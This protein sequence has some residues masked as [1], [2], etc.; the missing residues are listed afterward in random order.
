MT[1][2]T[3]P[4]QKQRSILLPVALAT[5][6]DLSRVIHE[7]EK[8]DDFLRQSA[9]RQP[10]SP[11]QLPKTSKVFEELVNGSH[12]N[13]LLDDDRQYLEH[14]LEWMREKAPVMH[15]AFSTDPSPLF[16]ERLITWLRQ[17]ISPYVLIRIGLHPNIGAGCVVRSTNKYFDFSLR[18]RFASKRELLLEQLGVVRTAATPEPAPVAPPET[19]APT[20]AA[21]STAPEVPTAPP[22]SAATPEPVVVTSAPPTPPATPPAPA[23]P[24]PDTVA[25]DSGMLIS[26]N[27]N[28]VSPEEHNS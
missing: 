7:L 13:M 18:Q 3:A 17:N 20:P 26:T 1:S 27:P 12:L 19:P 2:V 28:P 10:G 22:V 11:M 15:V 25:F 6:S 21:T 8:V 14:S 4:E 24:V 16:L 23:A 5:R 9:I